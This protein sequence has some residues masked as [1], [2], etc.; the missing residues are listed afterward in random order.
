MNR[1]PRLDHSREKYRAIRELM[2]DPENFEATKLAGLSE[3]NKASKIAQKHQKAFF[4]PKADTSLLAPA[5]L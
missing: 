3:I 4:F 2:D 5:D 1:N